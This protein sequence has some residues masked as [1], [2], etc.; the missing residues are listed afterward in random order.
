MR[1]CLHAG[2]APLEVYVGYDFHFGRDREGSMRLLTELGPRLG[3]AVTIIPEVTVDG[4]DVNSTRHPRLLADGRPRWRR[5]CSGAL[6][7]R[8]ASCAATRAGAARL[9][10]REPRARE[11]GAAGAPGVYAGALRLLDAGDPPP[12]RLPRGHERR[13]PA[14][15]R[16]GDALLAEAHALDWSGDLYGRRVELS[17][18]IWLRAERRFPDVDALRDAVR[19]RCARGRR[20]AR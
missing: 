9:P 20:P 2:S 19:P 15:L 10:D 5:A 14:H 16:G 11:R 3:F 17:F 6:R 12:A 8:G 7:V 18:P 1:E 13:A 4:G